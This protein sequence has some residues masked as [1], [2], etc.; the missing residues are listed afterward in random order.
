MHTDNVTDDVAG[1]SGGCALRV[2]CLARREKSAI[3]CRS[4]KSQCAIRDQASSQAGAQAPHS[5][6]PFAAAAVGMNSVS[7]PSAWPDVKWKTGL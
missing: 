2:S 6:S 7:S 3:Q 1:S 4:Q 5:P